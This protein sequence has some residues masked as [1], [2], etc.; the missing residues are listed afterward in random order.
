M[1]QRTLNPDKLTPNRDVESYF[2]HHPLV[3]DVRVCG[4]HKTWKGPHGSVTAPVGHPGEMARGTLRSVIRAAVA[5]GLA[6]LLIA[7]IVQVAVI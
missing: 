3:T 7:L 2:D 4:S 1:A 5:A 6:V